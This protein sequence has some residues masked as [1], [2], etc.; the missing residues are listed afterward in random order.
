MAAVARAGATC[1]SQSTVGATARAHMKLSRTRVRQCPTYSCH[2]T[3]VFSVHRCSIWGMWAFPTS[4]QTSHF[5][6][7][8][9]FL[10][11]RISNIILGT[12]KYLKILLMMRGVQKGD[13]SI[14]KALIIRFKKWP[15]VTRW[16]KEKRKWKPPKF[17]S[18]SLE[19]ICLPCFDPGE[20]THPAAGNTYSSWT[21]AADESQ[22]FVC[23]DLDRSRHF[24]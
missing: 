5:S 11:T 4:P 16:D 23:S 18:F 8:F 10:T 19:S 9:F 15:I 24:F 17:S 3:R 22:L 14:P 1:H 12:Y 7:F 13:S 20:L 21:P 2:A 6:R